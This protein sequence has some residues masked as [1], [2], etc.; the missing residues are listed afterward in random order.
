MKNVEIVAPNYVRR[1]TDVRLSCHYDLENEGLYAIKW[2][3]GPTPFKEFYRYLPQESPPAL[4]FSLPHVN[5]DVS[6]SFT[7]IASIQDFEISMKS[8]GSRF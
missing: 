3:K 7:F 1:G 8:Y 5:V 2:Y 6:A 4:A